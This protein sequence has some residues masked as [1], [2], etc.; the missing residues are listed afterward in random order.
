VPNFKGHVVG[1]VISFAGLSA[2]AVFGMFNLSSFLVPG[3]R[4]FI[5]SILGGL[6]PDIDIHSQ[7]RKALYVSLAVGIWMAVLQKANAVLLIFILILLFVR[8]VSHRGI[9]HNLLFVV[10]VPWFLSVVLSHY[11]S[12]IPRMDY[13]TYVFFVG[14]AISHLV[15]DYTPKSFLPDFFFSS[16]GFRFRIFK[17][18]KKQSKS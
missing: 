2:L 10:A 18:S 4:G 7:G 1:G 5:A 16:G 6:A 15:L 17:K 13:G 3:I 9:T 12:W 11:A 14:G 8:M